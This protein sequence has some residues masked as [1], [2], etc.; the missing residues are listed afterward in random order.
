MKVPTAYGDVEIEEAQGRCQG[1][2]CKRKGG[3]M[4][5]FTDHQPLADGIEKQH[6]VFLCGQCLVAA[7][8]GTLKPNAERREQEVTL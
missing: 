1:A 8:T 3:G 7:V 4:L 6:T 5:K 2:G